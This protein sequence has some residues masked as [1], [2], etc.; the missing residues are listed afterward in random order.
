MSLR[1]KLLTSAWLLSE[2]CFGMI[3]PNGTTPYLNDPSAV[4]GTLAREEVESKF[5]FETAAE[6]VLKDIEGISEVLNKTLDI[7]DEK[8]AFLFPKL[9]KRAG[10]IKQKSFKKFAFVDRYLDT[11]NWDL[12]SKGLSYRIRTRYSNYTDYYLNQFLPFSGFFSP[13]RQEIQFKSKLESISAGAFQK[14]LETRFELRSESEPFSQ[15]ET[16]PRITQEKLAK[17][18]KSGKFKNYRIAPAVELAKA[19]DASIQ[20]DLTNEVVLVS[21]RLRNHLSLKNP[22]GSGPNPDQIF[23]ITFDIVQALGGENQKPI[24]T[25]VELEIEFERNISDTL[26]LFP[27]SAP[28]QV[29]DPVAKLSYTISTAAKQALARDHRLLRK[30]FLEVLAAALGQPP[31]PAKSKYQRALST[32]TH[33]QAKF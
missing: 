5:A 28:E 4:V 1:I 8:Q 21:R 9:F 18:A 2:T 15:G 26:S 30:V 10:Y 29:E 16:L 24:K 6:T 12:A 31:L 11:E 27:D 14:V 17:W 22:W 7:L 19:M 20:L 33:K 25:F 13:S 3:L 32:K 23:I